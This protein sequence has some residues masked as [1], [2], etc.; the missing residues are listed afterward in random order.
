[1]CA[2]ITFGAFCRRG[3]RRKIEVGEDDIER[4]EECRVVE[5]RGVKL[6]ANAD[7]DAQVEPVEPF[8]PS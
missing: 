4:R 3:E 7:R 5:G 1:M 8:Q 6:R 2:F